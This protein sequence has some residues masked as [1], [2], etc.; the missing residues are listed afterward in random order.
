MK[1]GE[2]LQ[3]T[4]NDWG[5]LGAPGVFQ[6]QVMTVFTVNQPICLR[7]ITQS[8]MRKLRAPDQFSCITMK[9]VIQK[10]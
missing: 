10:L 7:I 8:G 5:A 4:A 1:Y 9:R 3:G 2:K 6:H